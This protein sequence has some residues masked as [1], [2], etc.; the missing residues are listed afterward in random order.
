MNRPNFNGN[1]FDNEVINRTIGKDLT[2]F[3]IWKIRQEVNKEL[4]EKWV[5]E[6]NI[7]P[8]FS[9][10]EMVKFKHLDSMQTMLYNHNGIIRE[11]LHDTA[12]YVICCIDCNRDDASA[13]VVK[14]ENIVVEQLL[15]VQDSYIDISSSKGN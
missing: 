11:I 9:I 10:G 4:V 15:T 13:E 7:K 14:Y 6:N 3:Q 1:E 5:I 8:E 2:S 12:Q